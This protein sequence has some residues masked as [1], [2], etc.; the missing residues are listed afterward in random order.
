MKAVQKEQRV[1]N[2]RPE[3]SST[4][5]YDMLIKFTAGKHLNRRPL[6]S[7]QLT[8]VRILAWIY[9]W[10]PSIFSKWLR[11]QT[12]WFRRAQHLCMSLT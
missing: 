6:F 12:A 3:L 7:K 4:N 2:G 11:V 9:M 8:L 1:E 5:T 10:L